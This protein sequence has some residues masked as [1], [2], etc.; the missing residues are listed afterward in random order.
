MKKQFKILILLVLSV[1]MLSACDPYERA[2]KYYDK[3]DY[4][5]AAEYFKKLADEGN[6]EAMAWLGLCIDR[7]AAH[8]DSAKVWYTN[9]IED[10][11]IEWFIEKAEEGVPQ[12]QAQLGYCY[13]NGIGVVKDENKGLHWTRQSAEKGNARGQ[14]NLG[15]YFQEMN[16]MEKAVEYYTKSANQGNVYAQNNLGR[17]YE[18]NFQD[19]KNAMFW[20]EKAAN[21]GF[22]YAQHNLGRIYE[23]NFQDKAKAIYWYEKAANQGYSLSQSFLA[24]LYLGSNDKN[25]DDQVFNL[26]WKAANAGEKSAYN[27]LG[28]CFATGK[29]TNKNIQEAL[30][31]FKKAAD[32]GDMIACQNYAVNAYSIWSSLSYEQ[33]SYAVQ[34]LS[35]SLA[36]GSE[37]AERLKKYVGQIDSRLYTGSVPAYNKN[38]IR[39]Y[40]LPENRYLATVNEYQTYLA[41]T[42]NSGFSYSPDVYYCW[43]TEYE[44]KKYPDIFKL[45][46]PFSPSMAVDLGLSVKWAPQNI[47]A[48]SPEEM[49]ERFA[50]GETA[51]KEDYDYT[52]ATYKYAK[53]S[54][55]KLM[56]IGRDI[57]GTRYDAAT[58]NWGRSWR[59]PTADE[60]EELIIMCSFEW[61]AEDALVG[62]RGFKVTGPNGNTLFF[63]CTTGIF[64][65]EYYTS[66]AYSNSSPWVHTFSISKSSYDMSSEMRAYG[67]YVRAVLVE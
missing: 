38:D 29:G 12:I 56:P 40:S 43:I 9:A 35:K 32:N 5:R 50:W 46:N 55:D 67:N 53:G 59:M 2:I 22:A 58:V 39:T 19:K 14:L 20:Y 48:D 66:Q 44:R 41:Q 13:T 25:N 34:C 8:V 31:W 52:W 17:I 7:D 37:L 1:C 26:L 23:L 33:K 49:G 3:Q 61:V 36:D 51:P 16:D 6:A 4:V 28:Y 57:G 42:G 10:G 47:G 54:S 64:G 62:T 21:Q 24:T 63:P 60:Y 18:I 65:N 11:A 30:V 45:A 15:V 27:N